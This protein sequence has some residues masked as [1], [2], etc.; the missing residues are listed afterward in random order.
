MHEN[1]TQHDLRST[2]ASGMA[3]LGISHLVIGKVLNYSEIS[4]LAVYDRHGYDESDMSWKPKP[5]T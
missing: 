1:V 2:E 5:C 4:I 3:S